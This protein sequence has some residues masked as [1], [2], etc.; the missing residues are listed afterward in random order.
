[1]ASQQSDLLPV[2]PY[3]DRL[4]SASGNDDG[5]RERKNGPDSALVP[6]QYAV[7]QPVLPDTRSAVA[8]VSVG[9]PVGMCELLPIPGTRHNGLAKGVESA[10]V[11]AVAQQYVARVGVLG[12]GLSCFNGGVLAAA[13]DEAFGAG[14]LAVVRGRRWPWA[15]GE[16]VPFGCSGVGCMYATEFTNAAPV[17][18][19]WSSNRLADGRRVHSRTVAS[20]DTETMESGE[21]KATSRTYR[22]GQVSQQTSQQG[23]AGFI[24]H[25][26]VL[27]EMQKAC[28]CRNP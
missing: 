2:I 10:D 1:M 6:F 8:R 28:R 3:P 19:T 13:D 5:L 23:K 16:G 17:E 4:V 11:V 14:P 7:R 18:L 22:C 26:R 12:P 25:L 9:R 20:R 24:R 15:G 27:S 21:M